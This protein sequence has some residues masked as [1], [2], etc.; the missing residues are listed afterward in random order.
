MD[1]DPELEVAPAQP[2]R[3]VRGTL[4]AAALAFAVGV[5]LGCAAWAGLERPARVAAR[6]SAGALRDRMVA[7]E[8]QLAALRSQLEAATQAH[9]ELAERVRFEERQRA[10]LSKHMSIGRR[11]VW[12]VRAKEAP[13]PK[14]RNRAAKRRHINDQNL[15]SL[16]CVRRLAERRKGLERVMDR[17]ALRKLA[18]AGAL[19]RAS[20]RG[21]TLSSQLRDDKER[22]L[23]RPEANKVL[24]EVARR[25]ERRVRDHGGPR[26]AELELISAIRTHA[27]NLRE[28][29]SGDST[30]EWGLAFDLGHRPWRFSVP[31][32]QVC[33]REA[34]K[35]EVILGRLLA[36][37]QAEDK[38]IAFEHDGHFHV[39]ACSP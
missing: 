19:V 31:G 29:R 30:H 27:H 36:K 18:K 22:R 33:Q 7:L 8:G 15:R 34:Y 21:Y 38:L 37:M 14:G 1:S 16:R 26:G 12:T 20:G 39:T 4:L 3:R 2:P 32:A 13:W 5:G 25:F 35:L 24:R 6:A 10:A 17:A 28:G 11:P 23:L 9:G